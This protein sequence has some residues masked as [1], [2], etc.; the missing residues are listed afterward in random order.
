M[1][2]ISKLRVLN[3][4][5]FLDSGWIDFPRGFTVIVGQ[6]NSG[7]TALLETFR[8]TNFTAKPH[9][10]QARDEAT[11]LNPNC[12][13]E[14]ELGLTGRELLQ[15][16]LVYDT[17]QI[18][19]PCPAEV[20][21]PKSGDDFL[22]KLFGRERIPLKLASNNG[23]IRQRGYPTLDFDP[24]LPQQRRSL[25]IQLSSDRA[26][27][28]VVTSQNG[29]PDSI[30]SL[31]PSAIDR[32]LYVFKAERLNIGRSKASS[33]VNLNPDGSNLAAVLMNLQGN[34]NRFRRLKDHVLEI[35]PNVREISVNLV[36]DDCEVRI[37]SIDTEREDLAIPLQESGTGIGQVLAIL[38]VAVSITGGLIVVDEPNS[39]LHPGAA[40]KL[41]Q[42]LQTYGTNQYVMA[43]HSAELIT[44]AQPEALLLVRSK[45]GESKIEK[46]DGKNLL[47]LQTILGEVGVSFSDVFGY[48]RA[49]WVEG[50]TEEICFPL[51]L[52]KY[53][54]EAIRGTIFLAV[55]NTGD[56]EKKVNQKKLIWDIYT[57][58]SSAIPLL[59]IAVVFSFDRENR[60]ASEI[61]DLVRESRGK[62]R[63]LPRLSYENYLLFP[64]AIASI[65]NVEIGQD[66]IST[67]QIVDWL[68]NNGA[69][70]AP[71]IEWDGCLSDSSW[72][73][74]VHAPNLLKDLFDQ[75]SGINSE[76]R[77]AR[78]SVAITEWLLDNRPEALEPLAGYVSELNRLN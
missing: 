8:L 23:A 15:A 62:V 51:I 43:T 31:M 10:S 67:A 48:D 76:Y 55:K 60:K 1:V 30:P 11:P 17:G 9:R 32:T 6:N 18:W 42:I 57:R 40:K 78:H 74:E 12:V 68:K 41:V 28:N 44:T 35:F 37:W 36:E 53:D 63:F 45:D 16:I 50:P 56:F 7:K 71:R 26:S 58:L 29:A 61:D 69:K 27:A 14:V 65:L 70:Y 52:R 66:A 21:N 24:G 47:D 54:A 25:L 20:D 77:K 22:D 59:P 34:P 19:I 75:V 46:L 49:V 5:G 13:I 39:F 72:L 38:Y 73:A 64:D 4:K 3:Y 2:Q 33:E